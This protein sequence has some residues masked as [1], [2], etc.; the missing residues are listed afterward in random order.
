MPR[1]KSQAA[2]ERAQKV[3]PGG[4]NSPARAFGGVGGTPLFI[5]RAEGPYLYDLDGHRYLDYIGSWGPMILGHCHPKVVAAV[6]EAV[7][8]GSSYGAPCE[9]ESELA[10]L[11]CSLMPSMEM[12]RMVSSG[13][14]AAMSAVRLARGYTGRNLIVKFAGCYHGHVDA[15]LVSAGSSALTL[16]VP[17]SP[18]VPAGC[19]QDTVVLRY[20]DC[21]ALRDLF[22]TRGNLIAGVMLEPFVGNMGLVSPSK[23]FL[24]ELWKLTRRHGSLLIFDEVMTGFRLAPGGAQELLGIKPDVTV[25]GKIIGGGYPVGAYGGRAEVMK[26]IMP[27]GPVFQAG[28]LSGNPVAMAAGLATL[29]EL[30]DNPPYA[31]LDQLSK[32][33]CDGLTQFATAR[34]IPHQ[35]NRIGSMWTLFF[36]GTPVVDLDTAKTSNTEKFSRFFWSM[37]D[38]GVY[39]PCSQFEAAFT[40][41]A[42]TPEMIDTTLQAAREALNKL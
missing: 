5:A 9:K 15:L 13:T 14:E 41:A 40:S 28:T 22:A 20:N 17:S 21:Q 24:D 30:R 33:L 6:L 19:T 11:I 31:Q 4:V 23:E 36:T 8:N 25:L 32:R 34:N 29:K 38:R 26:K 42:H 7:H 27:A 37:M 39:L 18:G 35:I 1:P 10:E 3:I 12:V 16:G 2:F